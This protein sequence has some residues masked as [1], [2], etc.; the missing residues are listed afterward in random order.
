M[1]LSP[2][3]AA[4]ALCVLGTIAHA[5]V[6]RPM[7]TFLFDSAVFS[8]PLDSA[9]TAF[10]V[11]LT[12]AQKKHYEAYN[13]QR[14][15]AGLIVGADFTQTFQWL[16]EAKDGMRAEAKKL[17]LLEQPLGEVIIRGNAGK[18]GPV[19]ISLY[20]R[21]DDGEITPAQFQQRIAE[22]RA[23]L[24][25]KLGVRGESRDTKGAM[26]TTGWMWRKDKSAW[27]LESAL[28][29]T[30]NRPEFLRLRIASLEA[31]SNS[32]NG[33]NNT[34]ATRRSLAE[35]VVRKD[36]GDV[37]VDGVPMVDQG[38]KGYCAV[39]TTERIARYYGIEVDQHEIAQLADTQS[40]GG[41]SISG[42]E[43]AL[44]KM[45]GRLH[46]RTTK[47]LEFDERSYLTDLRSYN[48]AAKKAGEQE[49][50]LDVRSGQV[51][52]PQEFWAKA[53][54]EIFL[55]VK[56][57]QSAFDRFQGKVEEYVN[58]GIPLCWA[59]QLGMFKETGIPQTQGGHMRIIIGYNKKTKEILYSDSWG[60]GHELKRM[61]AGHA[62]CMTTALYSVSPT[63]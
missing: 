35:R 24:E 10:R 53:K 55:A 44:K 40:G 29:R 46:C 42:M 3:L 50:P 61:P 18:V 33:A 22:W 31:V 7:D 39:A 38:Q 16:S 8:K 45:T 11:E 23:R 59:L 30:E 57:E 20:N 26:N 54:P 14:K 32:A 34:G 48:Q 47:L 60:K 1:K 6:A 21:G 15:E 12:D 62:W 28:T 63:K 51:I 25:A 5:E 56:T 37:Y 52:H 27:L 2:T 13:A 43:D 4:L 49:F 36:N 19:S 41:T 9:M 17:S 58:Q